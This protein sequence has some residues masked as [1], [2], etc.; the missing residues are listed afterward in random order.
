GPTGAEPTPRISP[1]ATRLPT[2]DRQV[3]AGP[4]GVVVGSE[5]NVSGKRL[6]SVVDP[7]AEHAPLSVS[8]GGDKSVNKFCFCLFRV[9]TDIAER[10]RKRK[11]RRGKKDPQPNKTRSFPPP[12]LLSRSLQHFPSAASLNRHPPPMADDAERMAA[13]K[14]AYA[15]IILNTAKESAARILASERKG[16]QL[17]RSLSLT[18][19]DS[20]AMLLRLKA[21]MDSKVMVLAPS[22][23]HS[24]LRSLFLGFHFSIL[25]SGLDALVCSR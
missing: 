21:I 24:K 4:V 22:I 13:L 19:E 23:S 9:I 8:E 1:R 16:L 25:N 20:L 6:Y 11:E 17:Q 10:G 18:K 5:G 2:R 12:L 15:D 7:L 3:E 14:R